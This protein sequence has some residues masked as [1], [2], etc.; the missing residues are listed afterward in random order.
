[1]DRNMDGEIDFIVI[2]VLDYF[3]QHPNAADTANGVFKWWLTR[4]R[5]RCTD[6]KLESAL[7]YLAA[8]GVV[9]KTILVDGRT[10]YS[11]NKVDSE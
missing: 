5:V 10:L 8:K 2:K 9:R 11:Y 4:E 6:E 7:D 1:M 3:R